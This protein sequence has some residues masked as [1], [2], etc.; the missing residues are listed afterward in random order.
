MYEIIAVMCAIFTDIHDV[1]LR[2]INNFT[3]VA[4]DTLTLQCI[5]T[6]PNLPVAW[7]SY[8]F[9]ITGLINLANDPRV[10]FI[11]PDIKTS[12]ILANINEGD[13]ARYECFGADPQFARLRREINEIIIFPG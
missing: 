6:P 8:P 2:N 13:T 4:G 12:A 9:S 3:F 7:R 10:T 11:P 1:I 5:T